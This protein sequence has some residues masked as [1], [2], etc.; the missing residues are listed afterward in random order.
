MQARNRSTLKPSTRYHYHWGLGRDGIRSRRGNQSCK[1]KRLYLRNINPRETNLFE[2]KPWKNVEGTKN[3]WYHFIERLY[4]Q[5]AT[6]K[7]AFDSMWSC[8]KYANF[9][10]VLVNH[11]IKLLFWLYKVFF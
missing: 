4:L 10:I 8:L 7:R 11:S 3:A 6:I 1:K 5:Q 9:L 2:L